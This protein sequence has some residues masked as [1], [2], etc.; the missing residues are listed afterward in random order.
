M[1]NDPTQTQAPTVFVQAPL[2]RKE[3]FRGRAGHSTELK[4]HAL[5]V[6]L[7]LA[8]LALA[9]FLFFASFGVLSLLGLLLSSIGGGFVSWAFIKV[10][11]VSYRVD[12]LRVEVERGILRK[13]IDNLE[14]WRVKDL[15]FRQSLVQRMLS[16]GD[17]VLVT[18]D[19]T[20]PSVELRGIPAPRDLY[21]AL[22]D[23]VDQVR[24]GRGVLGVES[25]T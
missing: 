3:L 15:Q 2:E 12:T 9:V 8:G 19:A 18:S 21:D 23:A 5:G 22:R 16:V 11:S 6:L 14:L 13:R 24:R 4:L 25:T 10:A 1:G 7:G 17:I 20:N